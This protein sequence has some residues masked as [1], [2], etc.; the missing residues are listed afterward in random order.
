MKK[1]FIPTDKKNRVAVGYWQNAEGLTFKDNLRFIEL[2]SVTNKQ[3]D[4]YKADYKQEAI[5]YVAINSRTGK[6]NRAYVYYGK[7][8]KDIFNKRILRFCD[9]WTDLK[10]GIRDFK[11]RGIQNYTIEIEKGNGKG[12]GYFRLYTW[13]KRNDTRKKRIAKRNELI[14]KLCRHYKTIT[15]YNYNTP[16]NFRIAWHYCG[17][18]AKFYYNRYNNEILKNIITIN[19]YDVKNY[20]IKYGY[21]DDYYKGR[22]NKL[23]PLC[24]GNYKIAL[25]FVILHEIGH[26]HFY[27]K[28]QQ[29]KNRYTT[30]R[31]ERFADAFALRYLKGQKKTS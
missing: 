19:P 1:I 25:R 4:G 3:L 20:S 13:T 24:K 27:C 29:A 31:Q 2:S 9:T 6:Q 30:E 17:G 14:K 23:N 15:N 8:K 10:K 18:R 12:K 7:N 28:Y 11:N 22:A 21:K 26:S 5:F 16:L